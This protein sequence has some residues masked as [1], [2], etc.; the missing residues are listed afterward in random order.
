MDFGGFAN[1]EII[2]LSKAWQAALECHMQY[3]FPVKFRAQ[4]SVL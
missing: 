2:S 1:T 4:L 3:R